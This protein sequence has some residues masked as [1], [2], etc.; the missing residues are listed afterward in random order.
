M[1]TLLSSPIFADNKLMFTCQYKGGTI[2]EDLYS[3]ELSHS[4]SYIGKNEVGLVD[5][6]GLNYGPCNTFEITQSE[7]KTRCVNIYGEEGNY[8]IH[9]HLLIINR[10]TGEFSDYFNI[11][12]GDEKDFDLKSVAS[13][14]CI[15]KEQLF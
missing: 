10:L 7:I 13:G 11:K 1:L 3:M 4:F 8:T 6:A 15:K 12:Y 14:K 2:L 9:K 5:V